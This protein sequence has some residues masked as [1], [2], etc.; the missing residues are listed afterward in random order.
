MPKL[1]PEPDDSEYEH[2]G[3]VRRVANMYFKQSPQVI[4]LT[5]SDFAPPAN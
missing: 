5:F 4:S 1:H 3:G 2:G